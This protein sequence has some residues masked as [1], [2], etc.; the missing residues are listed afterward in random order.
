MTTT[1]LNA[2]S[3]VVAATTALDDFDFSRLSASLVAQIAV[4][5]AREAMVADIE[6]VVRSLES[7]IAALRGVLAAR[8]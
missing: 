3:A 2:D 1:S 4:E 6:S 5:S 7:E 8:P